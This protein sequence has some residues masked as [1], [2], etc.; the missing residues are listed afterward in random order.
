MLWGLL[1]KVS[2]SASDSS[3]TAASSIPVRP[4]QAGADMATCKSNCSQQACH[5]HCT[6]NH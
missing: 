5:V 6:I 2:G 3:S 1:L 4:M